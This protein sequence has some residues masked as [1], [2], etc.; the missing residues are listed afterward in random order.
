MPLVER[1]RALPATGFQCSLGI[2]QRVRP[3]SR[4]GLEEDGALLGG[5]V[6]QQGEELAGQNAAV[7]EFLANANPDTIIETRARS[8]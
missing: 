3:T 5:F 2:E 6:V 7:A 4:T 8:S 1:C